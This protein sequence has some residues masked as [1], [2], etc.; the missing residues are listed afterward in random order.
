MSYE[1]NQYQTI[2]MQVNQN[3]TPAYNFMY[4]K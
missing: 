2:N 4:F 3:K 1:K